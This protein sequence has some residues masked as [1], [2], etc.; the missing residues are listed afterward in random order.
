MTKI[1]FLDLDGTVRRTKSGK[2]FISDPYDQELIPGVEE[3][4][5]RYPDWDIIGITNQGGV[6]AGHKS[7]EDCI[8]E[9]YQTLKLIP[10]MEMI[11]F[12]TDDGSS[13]YRATQ[14]S[15]EYAVPTISKNWRD[16]GNFRKPNTGM[17][18]FGLRHSSFLGCYTQSL[19][20]G[21]RPEDER[22]ALMSGVPFLWA[23][24]WL[25]RT[26]M[27]M[28]QGMDGK[29]KIEFTL[30]IDTEHSGKDIFPLDQIVVGWQSLS[31]ELLAEAI[32]EE[33]EKWKARYIDGSWRVM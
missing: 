23:S 1:L 9:Q 4:I 15:L 25:Q 6:M 14:K 16:Y 11:L 8:K 18:E 22:C 24:D 28:H 19:M 13:V 27:G 7:L 26:S 33:Y 10:R 5:A 3:A 12:C 30:W 17:V 32:N 21:D 20:V 2:T 31:Q 29:T